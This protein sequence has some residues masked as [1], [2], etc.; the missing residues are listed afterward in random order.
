MPADKP[1]AP[2]QAAWLA[3]PSESQVPV[4]QLPTAPTPPPPIPG[5]LC[6]LSLS[7]QPDDNPP[8]QDSGKSLIKE[9]ID[10]EASLEL[11]AGHSR[12]IVLAQV[13]REV[14]VTNPRIATVGPQTGSRLV[15]LGKAPGTTA[16]TMWFVDPH[17][18]RKDRVVLTCQVRVQ[19]DPAVVPNHG[20]AAEQIPHDAPTIKVIR[21]KT[22]EKTGMPDNML[23][24]S[25]ADQ[26]L[27]VA[28]SQPANEIMLGQSTARQENSAIEKASASVSPENLAAPS[29]KAAGEPKEMKMPDLPGER[30]VLLRLL[31]AQVDR[32]GSKTL[33]LNLQHECRTHRNGARPQTAGLVSPAALF[34]DDGQLALAINALRK[35]DLARPVVETTLAR[36]SGQ[37]AEFEAGPENATTQVRPPC[38]ATS[39]GIPF[40]LRVTASAVVLDNNWIHLTVEGRVRAAQPAAQLKAH[41]TTVPC[42]EEQAVCTTIEL[43]AGRTLALGGFSAAPI[44]QGPKRLLCEKPLLCRFDSANCQGP[45]C[46][47]VILVTPEIVGPN[48]LIS[49][50]QVASAPGTETS[51]ITQVVNKVPAGSPFDG[52]AGAGAPFF[53]DNGLIAGPS[54]KSH[55]GP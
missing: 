50:P 38:A 13:P 27:S 41:G 1:G 47:M 33:G 9:V 10:P 23:E 21:T 25:D 35:L 20:I 36:V 4:L 53:A 5:A 16:L 14:L 29:L 11:M 49:P 34:V 3:N 24:S 15:V 7:P 31:V 52:S 30:K 19:P 17:D 46:D 48:G 32:R 51:K 42:E 2:S 55:K 12:I 6:S 45:E 40:G 18:P 39:K 22:V 54:G 43:P 26:A 8:P 44:S 37:T 28:R